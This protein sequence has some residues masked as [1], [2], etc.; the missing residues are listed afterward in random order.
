[1][2]IPF[3]KY[4]QFIVRQ[5]GF[6]T[7]D[8]LCSYKYCSYRKSRS[9]RLLSSPL[10]G[11]PLEMD[12]TTKKSVEYGLSSYKDEDEGVVSEVRLKVI[13]QIIVP[14][15]SVLIYFV[16]FCSGIILL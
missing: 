11:T 16:L 6:A 7:F 9:K 15:A 4:L 5:H 13:S 12:K 1:M 14:E 3:I 2:F 8:A 10:L